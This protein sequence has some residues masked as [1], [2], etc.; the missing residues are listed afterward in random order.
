MAD[1]EVKVLRDA[2]AREISLRKS[3]ERLAAD[4]LG[5]L[6]QVKEAARLESTEKD[7]EIADLKKKAALP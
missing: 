3:A 5:E 7:L 2:L 1:P 6:A 4:A